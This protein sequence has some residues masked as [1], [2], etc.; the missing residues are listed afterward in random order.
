MAGIVLLFI[1]MHMKLMVMV[2][3]HENNI[4]GLIGATGSEFKWPCAHAHHYEGHLHI[5]T[6]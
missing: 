2:V 1:Y 6:N 4:I 5:R 3:T